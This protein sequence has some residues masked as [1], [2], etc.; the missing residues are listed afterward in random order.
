[1]TPLNSM[2]M[3]GANE[4]FKDTYLTETLLKTMLSLYQTFVM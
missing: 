1:M 4:G 2:P 3:K